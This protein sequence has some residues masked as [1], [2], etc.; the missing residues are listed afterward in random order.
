MVL[1]RPRNYDLSLTQSQEVELNKLQVWIEWAHPSWP[2]MGGLRV[3][4]LRDG[5]HSAQMGSRPL[6]KGISQNFGQRN[7]K[8]AA[9][10]SRCRNATVTT[11]T[12]VPRSANASA[13]AWEDRAIV[14]MHPQ[15]G[16]GSD[17]DA[18]SWSCRLWSCSGGDGWRLGWRS[19]PTCQTRSHFWCK[20]SLC[21]CQ[22]M[23]W[24]CWVWQRK[25]AKYPSDQS[26]LPSFKDET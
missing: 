9:A 12:P 1:W 20:L 6:A 15:W 16:P 5:E 25:R 23:L 3:C 14:K 11:S 13:D 4:R 7:Q 22:Y 18:G 21:G 8:K 24:L 26:S 10:S 17:K 19:H 2:Q